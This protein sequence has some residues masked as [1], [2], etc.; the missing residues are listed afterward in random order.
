MRTAANKEM[1]MKA[2]IISGNKWAKQATAKEVANW[3]SAMIE[4]KRTEA[5]GYWTV[6]KLVRCPNNKPLAIV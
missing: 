2:H 1:K 3:I 4:C 6:R 5:T